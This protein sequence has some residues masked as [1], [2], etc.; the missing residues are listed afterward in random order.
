MKISVVGCGWLGLSLATKLI[1][2]KHNVYGSTTSAEKLPL[3][4]SKG[5]KP[6]LMKLNPMPEGKD[7]NQLLDCEIMVI[8]IPPR[9]KSSPPEFYREQ[10]KYLKYQLGSALVKKVIFISSTSY[11]PNTNTTVNEETLPDISKGSNQAV[12]WAEREIGQINQ[13][14]TIL[15]CGGLMGKKRIPGRWFAGKETTGAN[16]PVNYVHQEDVIGKILQLLNSENWLP[17]INLVS[18]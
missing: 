17:I 15:R 14:L 12:V 10:I 3:L 13:K 11:Y 2:E 16:T 18:P 5:I 1:Q 4:E 7:F 8:N 6:Y 9:G